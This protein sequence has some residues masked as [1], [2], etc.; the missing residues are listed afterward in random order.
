MIHP[1]QRVEFNSCANAA[2]V[3][4]GTVVRVSMTRDDQPARR[5]L[6]L[7]Q[8]DCGG[9]PSAVAISRLRNTYK[10]QPLAVRA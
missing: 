10:S 7:V 3:F 5:D 9:N 8:Y 4:T 1:G 2:R 6:A